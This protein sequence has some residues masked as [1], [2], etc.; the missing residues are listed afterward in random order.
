MFIIYQVI[1]TLSLGFWGKRSELI[2]MV[3]KQQRN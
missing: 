1:A 3:T 2:V